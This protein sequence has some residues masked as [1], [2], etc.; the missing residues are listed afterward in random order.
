MHQNTNVKS[1]VA[2]RLRSI[3]PSLLDTIFPPKC[4][5]CL[6]LFQPASASPTINCLT[7]SVSK[8]TELLPQTHRWLSALCCPECVAALTTISEPLCPCCGMMFNQPQNDEHLCGDCISQPKKFRMARA[9]MVYDQQSMAIIHRFKY[10][11]KTQ[12]A[13]P[14]GGLLLNTYLRYWQHEAID[15]ILPVPLH[16]QKF[17]YRGFNQS[18][19]MVDRWKTISALNPLAA[20]HTRLETDVL[21][22]SK[23]TVP[24]TG[25]GR[26]QRLKNVR[27][28][29]SVR[30]PEMVYGR[31]I[32]VV[33]DVYTTGATVDEC[34]RSLLAAGAAQVDVLTLA[35]AV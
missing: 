4:L 20:S 24:Q 23:A 35:R 5:V 9:A 15:L 6:R 11:G 18:Y 12:L 10:A 8:I 25:L 16:N 33:D 28:A 22:R 13:R 19:L 21:S 1:A 3:W 26:R 32:L 7:R 17:R 34:A 30:L 29:F 14:F 27:G 2:A 31:K